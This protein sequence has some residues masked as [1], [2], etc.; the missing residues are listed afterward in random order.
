[1]TFP[2]PLKFYTLFLKRILLEL[3]NYVLL[4]FCVKMKNFSLHFRGL[5]YG[6]PNNRMVVVLWEPNIHAC[7]LSP[8][9]VTR[10]IILRRCLVIIGFTMTMRCLTML[11]TSL[12][13]TGYHVHCGRKVQA[14]EWRN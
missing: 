11:V 2:L 13:V 9:V 1:M 3:S 12:S 5:H 8:H 4:A 7:F 6:Y 14:E 10:L